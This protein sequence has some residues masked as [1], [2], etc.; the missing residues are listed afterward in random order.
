MTTRPE[1]PSGSTRR[2]FVRQ[3]AL[4]AGLVVAG[5]DA[6]T[7]QGVGPRQRP[8]RIDCLAIDSPRFDAKRALDGGF[9]SLVIDL[10][11]YPRTMPVAFETLGGWNAAVSEPA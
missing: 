10:Q 3:A 6:V 5:A 8:S 9:T 2:D 7:G 1:S 4:G 11:M